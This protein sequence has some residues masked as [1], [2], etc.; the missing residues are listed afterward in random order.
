MGIQIKI[1]NVKYALC[2]DCGI[3]RKPAAFL[4]KSKKRK[5]CS[6][7]RGKK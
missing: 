1:D 7:C 3:H 6:C 2:K 4:V 5:S